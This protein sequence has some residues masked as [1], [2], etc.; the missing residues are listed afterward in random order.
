MSAQSAAESMPEARARWTPLYAVTVI[1]GAC[2]LFLVQPLIAKIILPWFGGSSAVWSAALVFFQACV[3][4]GY[5]YAHWLTRL[6]AR[7]QSLIHGALLIISCLMMPILP[8]EAWRPDGTG[9]PA[10]QILLL[11][12]VTVGLPSVMLSSTS[13]LMQVW[14]MRRTGSEPPYWLFAWSNAGS[15]LALLSFPLLLE[16]AFTS[17][18]LGLGW[19]ALFVVFAALCIGVACLNSKQPLSDTARVSEVVDQTAAPAPNLWRMVLWVLLSACASGLLVTVS[20][21]LSANVAPIPLLWV[22]PLALYLLTFILAF[23]QHRV[24]H[25]TWYFPL[26]AL[27]LGGLAYLYVQRLENWPIQYVVPAYLA[28]LFVICMACH[29]ELVMRRPAGPYLTRFYL[30]VSLGGVLGGAFVGLIAP[31]IF[32]TYVELPLLLVLIAELYVMLQWHRRGSGRSLLLIRVVMI[33]GVLTLMG[34]LLRSELENRRLSV[35]VERNFYGVLSVQ[36]DPLSYELAR[37]YLIH[38]TI[39]HGYQYLHEELHRVPSSYFSQH[40][41]VGLALTALRSEGPVRMGVVGLGV[42]VLSGYVREGDY[43]RFYEIN[44]K[45]VDIADSYFTFLPAARKAGDVDVLLGDARLTLERQPPQG[46]DLLA[47][48]AFSSD[49]IPT[50]L[51]TREAFQLYFKH[52]KPNGVLAVHIS[53]RYIDLVPVCARSAQFVNRSA[54][55]VT[56]RSDGTYDTSVWVIVT[57]NPDLLARPEFRNANTYEATAPESFP[58]WSDQYSSVWTLMRLRESAHATEAK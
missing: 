16:P 30:L 39:S 55:V 14:Y 43:A 1:V 44:P 6:S 52:L 46:F 19:S 47:I 20:A 50:H 10:L 51:L 26:V 5:S 25:A 42:G 41:G 27:S 29:G 23:S 17:R 4:G 31:A 34:E 35:L 53:N 15:L 37:R 56:S 57:S 36:D 24:Y 12:T 11:L 18:T 28:A 13:P 54:R 21:N 45:V 38:G 7:R 58:G 2:L 32:N 33:L 48:D 49:A 22:V 40:S 8:S 9:D 3:L